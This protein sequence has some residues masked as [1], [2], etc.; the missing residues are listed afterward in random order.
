MASSPTG[1]RVRRRARLAGPDHCRGPAI[2]V[3]Q[4]APGLDRTAPVV[5]RSDRVAAGQADAEVDPVRDGR[6][7]VLGEDH[8]LVAPGGEVGQR[9]LV[10]LG[11]QG[12]DPRLVGRGHPRRPALGAGQRHHGRQQGETR[13]QADH[14]ADPAGRPGQ[15]LR[16]EVNVAAEEGGDEALDDPG[17]PAPGADQLVGEDADQGHRDAEGDQRADQQREQGLARTARLPPGGELAP[18]DHHARGQRAECGQV[19]GEPGQA[20]EGGVVHLSGDRRS[21]QADHDH[22]VAQQRDR[23]DH[24]REHPARLLAPGQRPTEDQQ[25]DR[26]TD[27]AAV[28]GDEQGRVGVHRR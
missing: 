8:R 13:Q 3:D 17:H 6:A 2:G 24:H 25:E 5:R 23:E 10:R 14:R 16:H 15:G 7:A 20:G 12:P 21:Q 11:D 22:Q 28:D 18:V 1:P 27:G 4:V 26:E 19:E 9:V